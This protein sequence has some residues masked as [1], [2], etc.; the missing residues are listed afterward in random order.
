MLTRIIQLFGWF[1]LGRL[2]GW[3]LVMF[4][5]AMIGSCAMGS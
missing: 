1:I 5:L 2:A 3:F 4:S